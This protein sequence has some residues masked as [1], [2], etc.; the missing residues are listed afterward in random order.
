MNN[1]TETS[2]AASHLAS[3]EPVSTLEGE[4]RAFMQRRDQE[5]GARITKL[6]KELAE[7]KRKFSYL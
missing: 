7:F 3:P 6:E 1:W 2:P 5:I 4:V